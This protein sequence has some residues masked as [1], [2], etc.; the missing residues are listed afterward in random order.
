MVG[1]ARSVTVKEEILSNAASIHGQPWLVASHFLSHQK[2][3]CTPQ[4]NFFNSDA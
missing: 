1:V 2:T 4:F 3:A